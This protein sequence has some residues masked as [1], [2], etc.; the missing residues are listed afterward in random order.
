MARTRA[1]IARAT[2]VLA[3]IARTWCARAGIAC[4]THVRAG[5]ARAAPACAG[6]ARA[7]S[8]VAVAFALAGCG[9]LAHSKDP[10]AHVVRGPIASRTQEPILLTHLAFRP[11]RASTQPEG[12]TSIAVQ[13]AYSSI[14]QTGHTSTSEIVFDCELSRTSFALR[15]ALSD[16]TDIEVEIA[17][18]YATA[19]F[20]DSFVDAYHHIL[21]LPNEHRSDRPKDDYEMTLEKDGNVAYH[22]EKDELGVA[23]VPIVVTHALQLEGERRPA[24]AVRAGI[25][26]PTG[27][28]EKGFGNGKFDYGAGILAEKSFGRWTATGAVD[29]T[30]PGT[31]D[32]LDRAGI[33]AEDGF[34]LQL[35]IEY[36]WNDRMSLLL[37]AVLLPPV[38]RD[39]LVKQLDD[40]ILS[41]DVGC[42]WDVGEGSRVTV[43]L[44]EDAIANAGPDFTLMAGW[45]LSM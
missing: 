24:I 43:G 1:R 45:T 3:R 13:E 15:R 9:S 25:E 30:W 7:A 38:T 18:V 6:I 8:R 11:R 41:I 21:G 14:Y 17:A 34:D 5:T 27:S 35:G 26:L 29:Y 4:T 40:Q 42:A 31:S 36:R 37:G 32:A 19:G 10:P 28:D 20:L 22:L 12:T 39:V 23:D 33:S 44:E 2:R 16:R